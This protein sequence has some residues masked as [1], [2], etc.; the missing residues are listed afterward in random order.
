MSYWRYR[1]YD[2][3]SEATI[4]Y[5]FFHTINLTKTDT[6]RRSTIQSS[7]MT[8]AHNCIAISFNT[9]TFSSGI[10]IHR[11]AHRTLSDVLHLAV[12]VL[13]KFCALRALKRAP[14]SAPCVLTC[15]PAPWRCAP[16]S[17]PSAPRR[18]SAPSARS[19]SPGRSPHCGGTRWSR[20]RRSPGRAPILAL[21]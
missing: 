9:I 3:V 8:G 5:N 10:L 11:P 6:K 15:P 16:P 17:A 1:F 18:G 14:R 2:C 13:L 20:P 12:I 21:P 4:D 7:D 19:G